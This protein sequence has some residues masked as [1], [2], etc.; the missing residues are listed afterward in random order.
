[1]E[2]GKIGRS[3]VS[4]SELSPLVD[5]PGGF[6]LFQ[7]DWRREG[8]WTGI[9]RTQALYALQL[10]GHLQEQ[11][12]SKNFKSERRDICWRPL[13]GSYS[14]RDDTGPTTTVLGAIKGV[15]RRLGNTLPR[16]QAPV[17]HQMAVQRTTALED[18]KTQTPREGLSPR[19]T[20]PLPTF[21]SH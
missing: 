7:P 2:K 6:P 17:A 5:P 8:R 19:T 11:R 4:F 20:T 9:H 13:F 3:K 15:V 21:A 12:V 10:T 1:M 18:I 16:T 14:D